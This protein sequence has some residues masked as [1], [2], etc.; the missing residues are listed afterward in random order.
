MFG[1]PRADFEPRERFIRTPALTI[2]GFSMHFLS[3]FSRLAA[4]ERVRCYR[5]DARHKG[6]SPRAIA[7]KGNSSS[8]YSAAL[9]LV[10][11]FVALAAAIP[12]V[13]AA[14]GSEKFSAHEDWPSNVARASESD[15]PIVGEDEREVSHAS[16][17]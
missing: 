8:F 3:G 17:V 6:G 11:G 15:E 13:P 10:A 5:Q 2:G 4:D 7:L 1:H 9:R 12:V 16:A 14:N